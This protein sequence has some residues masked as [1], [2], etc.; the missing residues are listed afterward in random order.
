MRS[1]V[2]LPAE[3]T[4]EDFRRCPTCYDDD[5]D[6]SPTGLLAAI[7][8]D[9]I[10]PVRSTQRLLDRGP[11]VTRLYST[12]SADEMT[13][14]PMFVFNADLPDVNNIHSAERVIECDEDTY[15]SAANWRIDFPQGTTIRGTPDGVGQWPDAVAQQ[16]ANYQVLM[17]AQ[18]GEGQVVADNSGAIEAE[19]ATYNEAVPRAPKGTPATSAGSGGG[20]CA[21]GGASSPSR[22]AA[23]L[24]ALG[25]LLAALGLRRRRA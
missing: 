22:P 10:E 1:Q 5:L 21:L 14:D 12:L 13:A 9:V 18:T 3:V 23:A 6:F 7:E 8:T 15:E 4:F 2:T 16:P 20:M 11:Y 25:G 17:L 19:L 24:A